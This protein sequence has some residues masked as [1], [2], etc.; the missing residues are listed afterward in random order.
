MSSAHNLCKTSG[1]VWIQSVSHSDDIPERFFSKNLIVKKQSADEKMKLF[2]GS[3]KLDIE[4]S[5][6]NFFHKSVFE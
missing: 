4:L 1:L 3:K 6:N 2:T 5:E